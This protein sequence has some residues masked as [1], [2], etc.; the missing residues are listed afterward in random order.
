MLS[1]HLAGRGLLLGFSCGDEGDGGGGPAEAGGQSD[2]ARDGAVDGGRAQG[3]LRGQ[4]V[5]R[6]DVAGDGVVLVGEAVEGDGNEAGGAQGVSEGALVGI[7]AG[8][9]GST[10]ER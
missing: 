8:G 10:G 5:R 2:A 9:R 6:A 3:E 7:E 4:W 1:S